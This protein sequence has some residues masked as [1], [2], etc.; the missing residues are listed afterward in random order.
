V[1]GFIR[2]LGF[3]FTVFYSENMMVQSIFFTYLFFFRVKTPYSVFRLSNF[4]VKY[5]L[6]S[7][8]IIDTVQPDALKACLLKLSDNRFGIL[9]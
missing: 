8:S 1:I 5:E 3:N 6:L 4:N 2:S 9:I 7:V